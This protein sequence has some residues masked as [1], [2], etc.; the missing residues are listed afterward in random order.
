MDNSSGT[1]ENLPDEGIQQTLQ[2][3][4]TWG[5]WARGRCGVSDKEDWLVHTDEA[6][7]NMD[8][9]GEEFGT[10]ENGKFDE[11]W[12]NIGLEAK[13]D[14]PMWRNQSVRVVC[15]HHYKL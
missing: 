7:G 9:L 10:V 3:R 8:D 13:Q 4:A 11:V 1:S 12:W 6:I 14:H 15:K 2:A 5:R